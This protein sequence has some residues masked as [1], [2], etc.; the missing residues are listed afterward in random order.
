MVA[1]CRSS[2]A[3]LNGSCSANT[4]F[5][6]YLPAALVLVYLVLLLIPARWRTKWH[7][8]AIAS[9]LEPFVTPEEA[10]EIAEGERK[11][12]KEAFVYSLQDGNEEEQDAASTAKKASAA[13]KGKGRVLS[14]GIDGIN[15]ASSSSAGSEATENSPLLGTDHIESKSTSKARHTH[16]TLLLCLISALQA[17][18]WCFVLVFDAARDGLVWASALILLTWVYAFSRIALRPQRTPP[19]DLFVLFWLH[20]TGAVATL[21]GLWSDIESGR[22]SAYNL[23]LALWLES[24]NLAALIAAQVVIFSMPLAVDVH[25]ESASKEDCCSLW[26]WTTLSWMNPLINATMSSAFSKSDLWIIPMTSRAAVLYCKF[27]ELR[28]STLLRRLYSAN[29]ADIWKDGSLTIASTFVEYGQPLLLQQILKTIQLLSEGRADISRQKAYLY[30]LLLLVNTL[31]GSQL[32]VNH[33]YIGRRTI[34]RVKAELVT[35]IYA[36]ALRRKDS[37]GLIQAGTTASTGTGTKDTSTSKTGQ[38]PKQDANNAG[39]ADT[40]KIVSIMAV[41]APRVADSYPAFYEL[42]AA[43]V[44]LVASCFFLYRLLGWSAIVGCIS[45]VVFAYLQKRLMQ[46][47]IANLRKNNTARDQRMSSLNELIGNLKVIRLHGWAPHWTQRVLQQRVYE[48]ST[49]RYIKVMQAVMQATFELVPILV[50]VLTFGCYVL[51]EEK[52]L[53]APTAF[54]ALALFNIL[55]E[56]ISYVPVLLTRLADISTSV[57]RIEEFLAEEDVPES[58]QSA[59]IHPSQ[60]FDDRI[61]CEDATFRWRLTA[62][63]E[64]A[65]SSEQKSKSM[66]SRLRSPFSKAKATT[67]TASKDQAEDEQTIQP[68]ELVDLTVSCPVG[69][70]TLICG[71]TGSGKSSLLSAILGEMDLV[72]GKP[73]WVDPV[74]G[75][76]GR[77]AYCSQTPWL[78]SQSIKDNILFGSAFQKERYE[79]VIESCA[80]KPDLKILIDG[81][82]TEIGEKGTTLSGGQKARVALARALYSDAKTVF[83]DDV[84]SAVDAHTASHLVEKVLRGR[85]LHNR[86]V[87]LVS[88][89]VTL[90]MPTAAWVI[91]LQHGRI[92]A[93]GTPAEIRASGEVGDLVEEAERK[94]EVAAEIAAA[95]D[96]TPAAVEKVDVGAAPAPAVPGKPKQLITEEV[97]ARGAV[98]WAVYKTFIKSFGV[99]LAACVVLVAF[100][101]KGASVGSSIWLAEWTSRYN[102]TIHD[103]KTKKTQDLPHSSLSRLNEV[104]S[105]QSIRAAASLPSPDDNVWPYLL[106]YACILLSTVILKTFGN[107]LGVFGQLRACKILFD[108]M[109]WSVVRAPAR[110][111]DTTPLGRILNRFSKDIQVLDASLTYNIRLFFMTSVNIFGTLLVITCAIPP[112]IVPAMFILGAHYWIARG[113]I[114]AGRELRRLIS[115]L[116]SPIF[117]AFGEILQGISVIRAFG[118]EQ[119][120]LTM[121]CN[122]VD[123]ASSAEFYRWMSNRWLL[124]RF[125]NLGGLTVFATSVLSISGGIPVGWTGVATAQALLLTQYIHSLC[126]YTTSM[127]QDLSSVERITEYLAPHLPSETA[128]TEETRSVPAYWPSNTQGISVEGLEFKYAPEL[129]PVLHKISFDVKP[130]ERIA[131]VG[132]TGSG[133]ST[134]A[135]ALLRFNEFAAGSVFIDGIDISTIDLDDLRSRI[136]LIPQDPVMFKG[137][138]RENLDPLGQHDD[139]TLIATLQRCQLKVSAA[140]TPGE[141]TIVSRATSIKDVIVDAAA[142]AK[143]GSVEESG[144]DGATLSPEAAQITL[145]SGAT[146][147]QGQRQL[148]AMARSILRESRVCIMDESTASLDFETD[149]QIQTMIRQEFEGSILI[150]IAHRL[151]TV[152]DYDRVL[153]MENGHIKEYDTPYNLLQN[154]D[155]VFYSMVDKS[156]DADDLR[157]AAAEAQRAQKHAKS[158]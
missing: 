49:V 124:L 36:K 111:I 57:Q 68:F 99:F 50:S 61:G 87:L 67:A 133:K 7:R 153:V 9:A 90:V 80:L 112:F 38:A 85:L 158:M 58:I 19:Y 53:D 56:P 147:S 117:S 55:G 63:K 135:L 130:G 118:A 143:A 146:L 33:L 105:L 69:K 89:H 64:D 101:T 145:D 148:L 127:E 129:D 157:V 72:A 82:E 37:S 43:P 40:G 45:A 54:T 32:E 154:K 59:L 151:S 155:G 74:N 84:L 83:L 96:A 75:L 141:S 24:V 94:E 122:R 26:S 156:G 91:R 60:P 150:T 123:V 119:S 16:A 102:T 6:A 78:R 18:A 71:S 51:V 30:S 79:E 29:S 77:V 121:L 81:D 20:I 25:E 140:P 39:S 92:A 3:W 107:L 42:L 103:Q 136:T 95:E 152:I 44:K 41:D 73:H 10:F 128:R 11:K 15:G 125:T 52:T 131:V 126:Q 137:T 104:Q 34:A 106:I 97:R 109:L 100:A 35:A 17:G 46:L 66:F 116:R 14:N 31:A 115:T 113:Y 4:I 142:S 12:S 5:S 132:R 138:V 139:A 86:T 98:R 93:Q 120:Y 114:S 134:L 23:R 110:W 27:S 62:K 28:H 108:E 22:A 48:L 47:Y 2:D 65:P 88:H 21:Y 1:F 70:L 13:L 76:S 149:R 144:S 8:G